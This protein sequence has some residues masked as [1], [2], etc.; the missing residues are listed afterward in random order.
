MANPNILGVPRYGGTIY[1]S[2]DYGVT[3]SSVI[4]VPDTFRIHALAYLDN[5]VVIATLTDS[6]DLILRSTD[7]GQNWAGLYLGTALP[8]R[9]STACV[10]L[11]SGIGLIGVDLYKGDYVAI[12][13]PLPRILKTTDY[14]VT[15][16]DQGVVGDIW[17]DINWIRKLC[18]LGGGIVLAGTVAMPGHKGGWILRSTDF[19]ST[20][21]RVFNTS[22]GTHIHISNLG[23]GEALCGTY[24]VYDR[25]PVI[26]KTTDWGANWSLFLEIPV[27]GTPGDLLPGDNI[28]DSMAYLG[29]TSLLVTRCC[30]W[31]YDDEGV[32]SQD[33]IST[34]WRST[35]NGQSWTNIESFQA[36]ENTSEVPK[37]S[38]GG[39]GTV[40]PPLLDTATPFKRFKIDD[41]GLQA[42]N[43]I[44]GIGLGG[45]MRSANSG[46]SF[47]PVDEEAILARFLHL[48]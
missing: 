36:T 16:V 21:A 7:Y 26:Y 22:S 32:E 9:H 41:E 18:Y 35:D 46:L 17:Y 2:E 29:G 12:H 13:T 6:D 45:T 37:A 19:G 42:D 4:S 31:G 34:I 43:S 10:S 3:W 25:V 27:G 38:S 48:P 8:I 15:W 40:V 1:A 11:G 47:T 39:L 28:M 33:F 30:M 44:L 14:G 20:W 23:G 24:Y 5:G